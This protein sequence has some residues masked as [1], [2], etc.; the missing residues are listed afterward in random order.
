MR[1]AIYH[2][3][4]Y[5]HPLTKP[6][7]DWLGRCAFTG[8]PKVSPIAPELTASARRYGFHATIRAPFR[9]AEGSDLGALEE[10]LSDLCAKAAPIV[11]ERLALAELGQ[12]LA[13]VAEPQPEA[14]ALLQ[15]QILELAEPFRAPLSE[16]E[17]ARRKPQRLT[18]RQRHYLE[19]WG[20]PY[21]LKDF[22]FHMTLTES[23][24][25]IVRRDVADKARA[26]FAEFI[27]RPYRLDALALF[28]EPAAGADFT[29]RSI[30]PFGQAARKG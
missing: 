27:D 5:A 30:H 16:A 13:L 26:H 21:V 12:F 20:Y 1:V 14:L 2:T 3:P 6:G 9:L 15:R 19:Q 22:R 8:A 7:A 18:D 29:I 24:E 11:F 23:L 17:I 28:V 4:P 10:R 25:P